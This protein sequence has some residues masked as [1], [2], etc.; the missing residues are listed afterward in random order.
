MAQ[1]PQRVRSW[2]WSVLQ[3]YQQPQVAYSDA[4]SALAAFP[5]LQPR[6]A[7]HT[8]ED[9]HS[10][11]LL[12]LN[13]TLPVEFRGA[14]YR[15]PIEIW[16]PQEYGTRGI[17]IV[18]Y[19]R[20][21][22]AK[23]GTAGNLVVRPGQHVALDGKIYHP[24]LRDWGLYGR[25]SIVEFLRIAQQI[26]AKEPPLVSRQQQ[27]PQSPSY[28][29]GPPPPRKEHAV[30]HHVAE[31]PGSPRP[32]PLPAKPGQEQRTTTPTS[33]QRPGMN[34]GPPLPPL[35]HQ[36]SS[37]LAQASGPGAPPPLPPLPHHVLQQSSQ[38][39]GQRSPGTSMSPV[40]HSARYQTQPAL[41]SNFSNGTPRHMVQSQQNHQG[42]PPQQ[43]YQQPP[44]YAQQQ[45]GAQ[46]YHRQAHQH[47]QQPAYHGQPAPRQMPPPQQ[48]PAPAI[49]LLTDPF[50]VSL[51]TS[52]AAPPPPIPPN[53][54][55]EHLLSLLSQSLVSQVHAKLQQNTSA[56]APLQAQHS[57]LQEAHARMNA[58]LA[59][60]QSLD[61]VLSTNEAILHQSLRDCDT[62]MEASAKTPAPNIDEVLVAPTVAANQLWN[63]CAEE[64]AIKEA[65]Y[66]LQRALDAGR[67]SG[68]DFVRLTRGLAREAFLKMALARKVAKGLGLE[69]G[70]GKED[71]G[72]V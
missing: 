69:L 6:T 14:Q 42:P 61:S 43:T 10:A 53:P 39:N 49:D 15:F 67:L 66:C 33:H 32:P 58:E 3:T 26:F 28:Q 13:G 56:I 60:L 23:D 37:S 8:Y 20:P 4:A 51:S 65:I 46:Q 72:G 2:L 7:I 59:Q 24:Y 21:E 11:L 40:D 54:E 19:I 34:D 57:A 9:G 64:A 48:K 55:K 63:L 29:Q 70:H 27:A 16:I 22:A 50:D 5:S 38:T 47:Y 44:Q 30:S 45:P 41:P 36:R 71:I 62:V 35:P 25:S 1:V 18:G 68:T 17:A 31:M 52:A 12:C